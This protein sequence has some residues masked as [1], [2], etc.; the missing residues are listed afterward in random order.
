MLPS[1]HLDGRE[2]QPE[3]ISLEGRPNEL[4][5]G[6]LL[7]IGHRWWVPYNGETRLELESDPGEL[8]LYL[9]VGASR[10][11]IAVRI[12]CSYDDD[13]LAVRNPLRELDGSARQGL[14]C[15]R[16]EAWNSEIESELQQL[17]ATNLCIVTTDWNREES[18]NHLPRLP[19]ELSYLV[20][21]GSATGGLVNFASVEQ[22]RHLRAL[23]LT[24]I[25]F[26]RCRPTFDLG[27]LEKHDDLQVLSLTNFSV[28]SL[29]SLAAIRLRS[30]ALD[31]LSKENLPFV[32]ELPSLATLR[33][34]DLEADDLSNLVSCRDLVELDIA[35]SHV[36]DLSSVSLFPNL[37]IVNADFSQT[38]TLPSEEL[39]ALQELWLR[40]TPVPT[41]V[42]DTFEQRNPHCKVIFGWT[43]LLRRFTRG[44]QR[45]IIRNGYPGMDNAQ[46]LFS[47]DDPSEIEEFVATIDIDESRSGDHC[48]C[49]GSPTI[50]FWNEG[51]EQTCLTVHHGATL[52]WRYW[53]GDGALRRASEV[54][55]S[56]W[57]RDR[58]VNEPWEELMEREARR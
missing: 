7:R 55:S 56:R 42:V 47:T 12:G 41:E 20:H 19:D 34:R 38:C 31:Q 58:G 17:G 21:D 1:I 37:R 50:E 2:I 3:R 11:P 6:D 15:V 48:Q 13:S 30:L 8:I 29:S 22:L 35:H 28:E 36:T 46:V 23:H 5:P 54:R 25:S 18:D 10:T 27:W 14:R 4:L 39:P 24:S 9:R 40:S 16:L 53:G 33:L 49:L 44:S 52:R 43:R 32:G 45:M 57:L 26:V 51:G